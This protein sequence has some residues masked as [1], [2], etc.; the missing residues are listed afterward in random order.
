MKQ[1]VPQSDDNDDSVHPLV[2]GCVSKGSV[3]PLD[4]LSEGAELWYKNNNPNNNL[5]W[6][7]SHFIK[8]YSKNVFQIQIG[9]AVLHAHRNQLRVCKAVGDLPR[10]NFFVQRESQI[11]QEGRRGTQQDGRHEKES[12]VSIRNEG[13]MVPQANEVRSEEDS[14]N[15]ASTRCSS[16]HSNHS[17]KRKLQESASMP[18]ATPRRSKRKR[19]LKMDSDFVYT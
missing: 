5:R 11:Q 16:A 10:P 8:K 1:L 12:M 4:A 15:Q 6:I 17:R 19:F 14:S 18:N 9:S 3:D 13:G 2:E 7:K